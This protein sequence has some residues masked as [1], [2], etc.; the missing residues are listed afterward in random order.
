MKHW[1]VGEMAACRRLSIGID[2]DGGDRLGNA[3]EKSK[4][5]FRYAILLIA[6][7]KFAVPPFW[8]FPTGILSKAPDITPTVL[9]ST[10]QYARHDATGT[11]DPTTRP[12]A[13]ASVTDREQSS[14]RNSSD[15]NDKRDATTVDASASVA[16]SGSDLWISAA[17][18][19]YI[20][21]LIIVALRVRSQYATVRRLVIN[22]GPAV[23]VHR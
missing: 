19:I 17:L 9:S 22:S 6:L 2:R 16:P 11:A 10:T 18:A 3:R 1:G 23:G 12:E 5:P 7:I 13:A 15:S 20:F 14:V 4:P 8:V 21:G